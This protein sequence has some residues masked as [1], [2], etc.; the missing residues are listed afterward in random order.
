MPFYSLIN[1]SVTEVCSEVP[2]EPLP[3]LASAARR[4]VTAFTS[5]LLI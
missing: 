2:S 1:I 4:P 5:L 3:R